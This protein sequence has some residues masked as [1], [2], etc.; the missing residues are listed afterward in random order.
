MQGTIENAI[1]FSAKRKTVSFVAGWRTRNSAGT[2]DRG[3]GAGEPDLPAADVAMAY[4]KQSEEVVGKGFA[5]P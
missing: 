5:G 3:S 1:T 4:A 2:A